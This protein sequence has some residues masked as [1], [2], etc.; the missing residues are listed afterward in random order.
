MDHPIATFP[1][2]TYLNG[3]RD[4]DASVVDALYNEFRLPVA[5]AVEAM[6]GSYADGNTFFRLALIQTAGLVHSSNYPQDTPI[7]LYLKNLAVAQYLDWLN[8]KGQVLPPLP[9]TPEEEVYLINALP[10]QLELREMR[11]KIRAKRQFVRLSIED[12]RQILSLA[13]SITVAQPDAPTID[14]SPYSASIDRYKNLL[15]E[16]GSEWEKPLPGWIVTP[17]T[18][19]KFH[20]IWSACEAL[21]RRLYSSQVPASGENKTIRYA[22]VGFML[23]TLGY[24]VFTWWTRDQSPAE[25][26]DHNFKPPASILEDMASRYAMDS[27]PPVRPKACILGFNQADEHYKN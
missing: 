4:A 19:S 15:E 16:R 10:T 23:L 13:N 7:F 24:A 25:V 14:I 18:D 5:R 1:N 12:Q 20:Q 8:E 21:E 22:F 9:E 11:Q 27:I 26:Y 6:G 3:L 2:E 17:L